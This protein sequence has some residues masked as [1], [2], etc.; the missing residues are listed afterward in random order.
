MKKE[1]LKIESKTLKKEPLK[2]EKMVGLNEVNKETNYLA[3]ATNFLEVIK[4]AYR[5]DKIAHE[6][7]KDLADRKRN[8]YNKKN[9]LEV[10]GLLVRKEYS[11]QVYVLR[12][13]RKT[14]IEL[15]PYSEYT[16]FIGID[17]TADL[18]TR[19]FYCYRLTKMIHLIGFKHVP[20]AIETAKVFLE[21]IFRLYEF[22]K[23]I[24]TD[25]GSDKF[26]EELLK[27]IGIE[28][29]QL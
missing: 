19:N 20:N 28:I 24:T 8:S 18:V 23:V 17:K 5:Q 26:L 14:T 13:F 21:N 22:P 25:R 12:L 4:Q 15:N 2:T 10:D 16:E 3:L 1:P 27:F 11:E 29:N 7:I 6:I 9:L